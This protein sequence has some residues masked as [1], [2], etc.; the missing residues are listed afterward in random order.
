MTACMDIRG[1]T[2]RH[3]RP[4]TKTEKH[5][6]VEAE[7]TQSSATVEKH[8]FVEAEATQVKTCR[9]AA[10][11]IL[12]RKADSFHHGPEGATPL[13]SAKL[14]APRPLMG[15]TRPSLPDKMAQ[16]VR[17]TAPTR[18]TEKH[19]FVEAEATRNNDIRCTTN[20]GKPKEKR[21]VSRRGEQLR[22]QTCHKLWWVFLSVSCSK[23]TV[24]HA[25]GT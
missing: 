24:D 14:C 19:A 7:A 16:K 8:A 18:E 9:A 6:F 11:V 13:H 3:R 25:V 15:E 5:A 23:A 21:L 1:G 17:C 10:M 2:S 4:H 20:T 12:D 22:E